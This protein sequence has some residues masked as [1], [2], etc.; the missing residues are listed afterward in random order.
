M[1]NISRE[2]RNARKRVLNNTV[3]LVIRNPLSFRRVLNFGVVPQESP[4]EQHVRFFR[5][6]L[7]VIGQRTDSLILESVRSDDSMIRISSKV[8]SIDTFYQALLTI[9]D[10]FDV[11]GYS[12]DSDWC[13]VISANDR[14]VVIGAEDNMINLITAR[15]GSED[16]MWNA[17]RESLRDASLSEPFWREQRGAMLRWRE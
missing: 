15:C 9:G 2:E 8:L 4:S 1:S 17:V 7:T 6:L 10:E 14:V 3:G 5:C 16:Q 11:I 12:R 13:L